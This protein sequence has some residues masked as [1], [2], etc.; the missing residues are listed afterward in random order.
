MLACSGPAPCALRPPGPQDAPPHCVL[1]WREDGARGSAVRAP[2]LLVRALLPTPDHHPKAAPS[3]PVGR[4]EAFAQSPG[5]RTVPRQSRRVAGT[6]Q[7]AA[8]VRAPIAGPA[9][10]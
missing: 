6:R 9:S 10:S 4:D 7:T 1:P 5:A 2:V 3:G 8:P